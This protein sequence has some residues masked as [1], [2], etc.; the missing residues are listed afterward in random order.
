MSQVDDLVT[1][2]DRAPTPGP[3]TPPVLSAGLV[4]RT[5][6]W[7]L[8]EQGTAGLSDELGAELLAPAPPANFLP[9]MAAVAGPVV[10]LRRQRPRD[11]ERPPS[12][13][14]VI[15]TEVV[16]GCVV[17][18]QCEPGIGAAF[19]SN[20]ALL[21]AACRAQAIATDGAWRDTTRLH[22][23]GIPLGSNGADPTRPAGCPMATV[24]RAELFGIPWSTG[25]WFLRDADGV[26]RLDHELAQRVATRL[27]QSASGE[28]ASLLAI[29]PG[30]R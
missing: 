20:V 2:S 6:R 28:L 24:P 9:P 17:L 19:G 26:M 13:F 10:L 25:D 21:A 29:A 30:A 23:V 7:T 27:A 12:S 22:A 14:D 11:G 4:E 15:R 3:G 1:T 8:I 18:V 16:A 5:L